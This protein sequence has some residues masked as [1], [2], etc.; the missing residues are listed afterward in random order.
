MII[1]TP[2]ENEPKRLDE[3]KSYEILDTLPEEQYD[4]ITSLVA[5]IC[6]TPI[7]LITLLDTNRN[8]LKS[9]HGIAISESPRDISFCAH[10]ILGKDPIFII[11]DARKDIRFKDNPLL[12]DHEV[13]FY[14][15]VPLVNDNNYALGTLCVYDTKPRILSDKQKDFLIKLGKQVVSLFELNKKNKALIAIQKEQQLRNEHL[16]TFA[17]VVTH[18]LKSPLAIIT[19]L[20]EMLIEENK[21]ILSKES[22]QYLNYIEESTI[23]SKNYIDGILKFYKSTHLLEEQKSYVVVKELFEN[24]KEML[25]LKDEE[26]IFNNDDSEIRINKPAIT[27]ILLN[28]VDNAFKYNK[29]EKSFVRVGFSQ[30]QHEYTFFV[31]DNGSGIPK[32]K[33]TAIFELFNTVGIKDKFGNEGT[34]IGLATVKNLIHKL[35]GEIKLASVLGKGSIFTFIIKK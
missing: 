22:L 9:H 26:F 14:A 17:R 33:Q 30:S 29:S 34:G 4:T 23:T 2:P 10:A 7:S 13:I 32:D 18:D 20:T 8:F 27:Q 16:Q 35:G 5:S 31:E 28:L 11:E 15:G 6:E 19:S 3:V 24:I 25:I 21:D 12:K 1:P